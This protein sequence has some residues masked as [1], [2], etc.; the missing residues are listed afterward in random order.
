[1]KNIEE[2][3]KQEL[4]FGENLVGLNFNPSEDDKVGKVQKLCA[5]LADLLYDYIPEDE[6]RSYLESLLFD[7]TSVNIL[8]A[9]MS[10]VKLLTLKK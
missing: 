9:Q 10:A 2:E 5:E 7:K 4:T 8:D 6:D 1:M 3:V